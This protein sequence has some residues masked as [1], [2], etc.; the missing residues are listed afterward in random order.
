[1]TG[2][3]TCALPILIEAIASAGSFLDGGANHPFQNAA[4]ALLEPKNVELETLAIQRHFGKK[5]ALLLKRLAA[6]NITTDAK[7]DG[8][9]YV[10]PN[11]SAFLGKSGVKST[12]ELASRLLHEAHV[13]AVP[14]EA[15]GTHEHIRLSYAVSHSDVDEGVVRMKNF[16]A[17]LS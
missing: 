4:L 8:A 5:R 9:F 1:M 10:Y 11:V 16:F 12:T 13:V 3:Q 6:M 2:V 17:G 15:F 7:P 14:G